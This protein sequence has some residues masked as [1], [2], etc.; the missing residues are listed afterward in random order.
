MLSGLSPFLDALC[1]APPPVPTATPAGSGASS[2]GMG[3]ALFYGLLLLGAILFLAAF[4][5]GRRKGL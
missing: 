4:F 3:G 1:A 5:Y 2:V